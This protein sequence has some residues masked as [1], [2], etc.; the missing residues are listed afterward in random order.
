MQFLER[1]EKYSP[2]RLQYYSASGLEGSVYAANR[3][4]GAYR[5]FLGLDIRL[6]TEEKIEMLMK[7]NIRQVRFA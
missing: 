7:M 2:S 5:F 3:Q 1:A 6:M 4:K